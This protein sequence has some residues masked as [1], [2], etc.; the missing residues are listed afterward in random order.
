MVLAQ[1]VLFTKFYNRITESCIIRT[2]LCHLLRG[3]CVVGPEV[4]FK[5]KHFFAISKC[6]PFRVLMNY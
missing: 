2:N 3:N 6:H 1:P 5:L 4:G